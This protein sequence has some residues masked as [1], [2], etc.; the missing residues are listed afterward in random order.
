MLAMVITGARMLLFAASD[1]PYF[2][3]FLL[4]LSGLAFPAMWLAGVAYAD[5]NAP[6]LW[7]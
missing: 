6:E 5:E 1:A 2:V 4:M 7:T 3:L